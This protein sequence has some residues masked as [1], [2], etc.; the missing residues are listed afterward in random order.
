MEFCESSVEASKWVGAL[1][2]AMGIRS[3]EVD[4]PLGKKVCWYENVRLSF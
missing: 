3:V 2:S 1:L 4:D